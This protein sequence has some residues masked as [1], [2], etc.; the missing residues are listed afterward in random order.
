MKKLLI[1]STDMMMIQFLIPHVKYLSENGFCVEIACSVVGCCFFS[2][3][4]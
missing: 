4:L 1:T 3:I 2:G